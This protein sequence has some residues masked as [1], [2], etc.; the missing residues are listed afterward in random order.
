LIKFDA[1][2]GDYIQYN[3]N[4][5]SVGT[6]ANWEFMYSDSSPTDYLMNFEGDITLYLWAMNDSSLTDDPTDDFFNPCGYCEHVATQ[7]VLISHARMNFTVSQDALCQGDSVRFHDSTISSVGIFGWGFKFDSAWNA[8]PN[9]KEGFANGKIVAQENYMPDPE[10]GHGYWLPFS[11]PNKYRVVLQD[12]CNF[13]CIRNDTLILSVLP[14]SVPNFTSSVDGITYHYGKADTLCINSGGQY[15]L[16]DSSWSPHPYE[17]AQIVAWRWQLGN[18]IGDVKRVDSVQNPVLVE[19]TNG[20]QDLQLTVTNEY[21]CDSTHTFDYQLLAN[22]IQVGFTTSRK[23]FCNKTE[24]GFTNTT[25]VLPTAIHRNSTLLKLIYEW[26]DGDTS[27]ILAKSGESMLTGHTY[28]LPLLENKV[29]VKLKASIVDPITHLP[30]G[31]EEEFIDSITISRPLAGFMDDGHKFPCPDDVNGIKGKTIQFSD[32]SKGNL[33]IGAILTWDFGDSSGSRRSSTGPYEELKNISHRYDDAGIYNVLLVVQDSSAGGCRDTVLMPSHVEI[34]GPRGT[35]SYTTDSSN[36]KPLQVTFIPALEQGT[37]APY[38]YPDTLAIHTGTGDILT[39]TGDYYGLTRTRRLVYQNAGA[40]LPT[41]FLYKTV[42]FDGKKETCIIQIRA[43]DTIYVIDLEPNFDTDPLYCPDSSILVTF[44]NTSTWIPGH[45]R[46]SLVSF[47]WDM[48]NGDTFQGY[49]DSLG[50]YN[51]EDT[52]LNYHGKTR[53]DSAGIYPVS[54]TMQ[55]SNCIKAK[56]VDIEVMSIPQPS[57]I[58]DTAI[59]CD[60]L[61]VQFMADSLTAIDEQRIVAYD[62]A[63]EDGT[64]MT[65]NP[66]AR[67]FETSGEYPYTLTLTFLPTGCSEV[68]YDTVTIFVHKSPEAA[69]EADPTVGEVDQDFTFTD[70]S[71]HPDGDLTKWFWDFGDGNSSEDSLNA[72]QTHAYSATSGA[73]TVS[74]YVEDEY[75]CWSTANIQIIVTE[76]LAF[77]N[78]FTPSGNC[79][80]AGKKVNN[81]CEFRPMEDKGYFQDFK[82]EIYDRWGMLVWSRQCTDPNCPDYDGD[83]F[84]WKGTNKQGKPVADGVYYW[85]V[86]ARPLSGVDPFIRSGSIT[87][88]NGQK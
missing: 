81:I 60:G 22:Y 35:F 29:I 55:V 36:C 39:N 6:E 40:Y 50:Y 49:Y 80:P 14:K 9:Y 27:E 2:L 30:L 87:V 34:L 42:E 63:F 64:T 43:E 61:E 21:G 8:D 32:T 88:V 78:I 85:T 17:S 12:T 82:M 51:P 73:I 72:T 20:L 10:Y 24:V 26:G 7:H 23:S 67:E 16:R 56:K 31:C 53:Y 4:G 37:G 11:K 15:Y 58:P 66:A 68:Y 54:L 13:G 45:L 47:T 77:P 38:Y 79:P 62:W 25:V 5:D 75:G 70:K 18:G 33:G 57:L 86:Y 52:S 28:D 76:K 3:S 83:G 46:D 71:T 69:L 59:A 48:A 65:G 19:G 84:W 44:K 41:Y 74:L 1:L